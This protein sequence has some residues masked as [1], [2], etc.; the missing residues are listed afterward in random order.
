MTV[1]TG[2][3]LEKLGC[4]VFAVSSGFECLNAIGPGSSFEIIL[5]DLH[6]S[7]MDGFE[8]AMRI[9]KLRSRSFPLIVALTARM[10][11]LIRKPILLEGM[12][13]ELHKVLQQ[14]NIGGM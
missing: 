6:M 3:L 11:G 14:A 12:V 2:K 4:L 8:V 7:E 13:I 9:S 1:L 5:L 10:N